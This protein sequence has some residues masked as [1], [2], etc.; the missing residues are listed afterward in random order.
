MCHT[1]LT[2]GGESGKCKNDLPPPPEGPQGASLSQEKLLLPE[3]PLD[4]GADHTCPACAPWGFPYLRFP[5]PSQRP[6][7][8]SALTDLT[9]RQV[10]WWVGTPLLCARQTRGRSGGAAAQF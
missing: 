5:L 1:L 10:W 7:K 4:T 3:T 2:H 8:A 6:S 9:A